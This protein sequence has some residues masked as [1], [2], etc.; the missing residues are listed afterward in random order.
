MPAL[1]QRTWHNPS[2][3]EFRP[4]RCGFVGLIINPRIKRQV[5]PISV[6]L[7]CPSCFQTASCHRALGEIMFTDS[8]ANRR[9]IRISIT[10]L[11]LY[12]PICLGYTSW[13]VLATIWPYLS[14]GCD[15]LL[16]SPL[17]LILCVSEAAFYLFIFWYARSLQAPA[18]HP[19]LRTR[20]E[21][22]RLFRK[23]LG[24]VGDFESFL[25]GWFSGAE[26]EEI[27]RD[28]LRRW[29]DW[30]FWEGRADRSKEQGGDA[31][32]IEG[33]V[34]TIEQAAGK[35]FRDGP[36]IAKALLLTLDPIA[37]EARYSREDS[38]SKCKAL[39]MTL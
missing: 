9:I 6:P 30:A 39:L 17:L 35:R 26:L 1:L 27:G 5:P 31:A 37:V 33:Y 23:V 13:K 20:E 22:S 2:P 25:R 21:R 16:T 38:I 19:P 36:G 34:K 28:E 32:E 11:R 10:F 3:L 15:G 7:S 14:F 18:S 12:G 8:A 4:R 24:E 29:I